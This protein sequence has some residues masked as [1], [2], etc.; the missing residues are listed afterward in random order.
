M[1]L[2]VDWFRDDEYNMMDTEKGRLQIIDFIKGK[3]YY[4]P[5]KSYLVLHQNHSFTINYSAR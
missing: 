3:R 5:N 4:T 2:E 1:F